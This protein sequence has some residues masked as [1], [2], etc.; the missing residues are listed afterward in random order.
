MNRIIKLF[1]LILISSC[2]NTNLAQDYSSL[3]KQSR[4]QW[5][6]KVFHQFYA[7]KEL[8]EDSLR[9]F[10]E[11][12][13]LKDAA[14][15][16]K[17]Q[18][19]QLE[20]DFL[21]FNYLS[22]R[23]YKNYIK[24]INEF[25]FKVDQTEFDQLKARIRQALGFHYFYE[26]KQYEKTV[27]NFS[28]SYQFIKNIPVAALPDKQE[29][30]YNIAYVYY[31]IGYF[32]STLEYLAIAEKLTNNYYK[33]LP[34]NIAA[35]KGM[36]LID[37]GEILK[38]KALFQRLKVDAKKAHAKL[39]IVISDIQLA[40]IHYQQEEY[41]KVIN[42]LEKTL[43]SDYEKWDR[44]MMLSYHTLKALAYEKLKDSKS[45]IREVG[46]LEGVL[47]AKTQED[48]L[49]NNEQILWLQALSKK[50]KGEY[51]ASFAL[52]DS[53]FTMSQQLSKQKNYDLIKQADNK[54]NIAIYLK[55]QSEL[56]YQK[57]VMYISVIAAILLVLLLL[58]IAYILLQKEKIKSKQKQLQLEIEK[59]AIDAELKNV[60][61][62]LEELTYSLLCKNHEIQKYQ[63]ELA[64]I[65]SKQIFEP[66]DEQRKKHLNLL[67][68]KA[69]LTDE[70]W[71][72]FKRAFENVH[73]GYIQEIKKV[74]P[75]VSES[76]LRYLVLKKIDLSSKEIAGLLGI[77]ADSI[78]MYRLRI[79]KKHAL[80]HDSDLEKLISK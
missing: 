4:N 25:K 34:L 70:K 63:E 5:H 45:L 24:E 66:E 78:R 19:L 40:K 23:N 9:F 68:S 64:Q 29:L 57:N 7:H 6:A 79:R 46:A 15:I 80:E 44:T 31:H 76:E 27:E 22:S 30:I 72:V 50:Y 14:V 26:T 67:L 11:V 69:L 12:S 60:S 2:W 33:E 55:Q 49:E 1:L 62:Q 21:K 43:L 52:M 41:E 32:E 38:S 56:K 74:L 20:M 75:L 51:L 16:A 71:N 13:K 48:Y 77:K 18:E 3:A 53:A 47:R 59:Q 73:K 54:E 28:E 39:W 65:E 35:T 36:I 42:I 61:V 10:N 37:R 8:R 58:Y 17:N